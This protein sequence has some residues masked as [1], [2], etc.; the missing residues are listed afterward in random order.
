MDIWEEMLGHTV[1]EKIVNT[2][3]IFFSIFHIYTGYFQL[4]AMNQRI[5]HLMFGYCLIFLIYSFNGKKNL[6]KFGAS[7]IILSLVYIGISIYFILTWSTRAQK[8]GLPLPMIDYVLGTI[9]LF[10]TIEGARRSIGL[11]L[12]IMAILVMLF[13]M[14]GESMPGMFMHKNY[15][16]LRIIANMV[17]K[18]D[19]LYGMLT[20]ISATFIYLL[21]LFGVIYNESGAGKFFLDFAMSFV[22]HLRGGIA[23]V[24]IIASALFGM[25]SG[26]GV[27]NTAAVGNITIGAMKQNNY[28]SDFAAAVVA[29][30]GSGGLI[31]P[32]IMGSAVFIMMS[33]TGVPY[34]TIMLRSFVIAFLFYIAIFIMVDFRSM[35]LG[36]KGE[37][38][39]KLKNSK[40][41]FKQGWNYILPPLLLVILLSLHV[42]IIRSVFWAIISI[43]FA[44]MLQKSTRMSLKN[45]IK[46]L[47]KGAISALTVVAILS[48]ASI[49]VGLVNFTGLGIMISTILIRLSGGNLFILLILTMISSIILG[50]GV[51]PVAAYVVLSILVVPAL[52]QMGVW[53]FAAHMFVFYFSVLAEITPPVAPNAYVASGIANSNFLKTALTAMK[54]SFP[55]I[56]MPYVFVYNNALLMKGSFL[57]IVS[58]VLFAL[59][60]TYIMSCALE[61]FYFTRINWLYSMA[62]ITGSILILMPDYKLIILGFIIIGSITVY[63]KLK[64]KRK[65]AKNESILTVDG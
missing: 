25:I 12:P 58:I 47:S 28:D 37:P 21:V 63:L 14:F 64:Q 7:N 35:K 20:G 59:I 23:K 56:I 57:Q 4:E 46:A 15:S 10:L 26:S 22:G 27:A 61:N 29:A 6:K 16:F 19:G 50:M 48:V 40:E 49:I 43:P 32:P 5:I 41:V 17:L 13:G 11:V 55:V 1:K 34:F 45:L 53:F 60:A 38:K 51:P 54:I 36:I 42:N 8:V 44:T 65:L 33:V 52:T 31:M 9:I 30:A 2:I 3:A 39:E 62:L 24:S 18:T